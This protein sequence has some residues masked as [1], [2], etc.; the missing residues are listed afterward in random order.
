VLHVPPDL[1]GANGPLGA[2]DINA[3]GIL[4]ADGTGNS[5]LRVS[6]AM[7][8]LGFRDIAFTVPRVEQQVALGFLGT[9]LRLRIPGSDPADP[10][11]TIQSTRL[12]VRVA[13]TSV[14]LSAAFERQGPELAGEYSGIDPTTGQEGWVRVLDVEAND[15]T[16]RVSFPILARGAALELGAPAVTADFSFAVAGRGLAAVALDGTFAKEAVKSALED[17]IAKAANLE[18]YRGPLATTLTTWLREGPFSGLSLREFRL[19]PAADGG[20][21]LM[22]VTTSDP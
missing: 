5:L 4:L 21:D 16:V 22:A 2:L 17:A 18:A 14:E 15:L 10:G 8:R 20:F 13:G 11:A 1:F 6:P 9:T 3:S 19:R 7:A 12:T